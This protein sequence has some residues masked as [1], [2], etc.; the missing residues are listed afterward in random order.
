MARDD[1]TKPGPWE[2]R[3]IR[4]EEK[5]RPARLNEAR[6]DANGNIVAT[7]KQ[8]DIALLD[9]QGKVKDFIGSLADIYFEKKSLDALKNA[10]ENE[11][12]TLVRKPAK[13][14]VRPLPNGD[15]EEF[16]AMAP[17]I[18]PADAV[19]D[20]YYSAEQ[21]AIFEAQKAR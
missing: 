11:V 20:R 4:E 5:A 8:G 16:S 18:I 13:A 9:A 19:S 14:Q 10:T 17:R 7:A 1:S 15:M 6:R 12:V 2:Y 3:Y 21:A